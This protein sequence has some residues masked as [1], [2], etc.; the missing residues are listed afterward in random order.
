M[1]SIIRRVSAILMAAIF[2]FS[3]PISAYAIEAN[4]SY[5][6]VNIGDTQVTHTKEEGGSAVTEDHGGSV[7]VTGSTTENNISVNVSEGNSV[8]VTLQ[9]VT[10]DASNN[11]EAA[12][13]ISGAGDVVVELDGN[14]SLEGGKYHAGLETSQDGGSLIIQDEVDTNGDEVGNGGSLTAEGG[15]NGA[16]IGGGKAGDGSNISISGGDVTANGGNAGAGIGGGHGGDG[17]EISISGGV[18]TATGGTQAAGIGGGDTNYDGEGGDGSNIE[19]TGGTVTANG[20]KYGAGIGGGN[21]GS[22]IDITISGDAVVTAT[23]GTKG[24]GIGGGEQG[25]GRNIEISGGE[26][27]ATGG[28]EAAGVGGGGTNNSTTPGGTG[29]DISISGGEVTATGGENAAGIGGGCGASGSDISISGD[30]QVTATGSGNAADVGSGDLQDGVKQEN[31]VD[32]SGLYT[33]G[34]F[35]GVAGIVEP[36]VESVE[37]AEESDDYSYYVFAPAEPFTVSENY[38]KTEKDGVLTVTVRGEEAEL[39]ITV[40]GIKK[41]IADGIHT[42]VFVTDQAETKVDL[43]ELVKDCADTDEFVISHKGDVTTI[44]CNGE[45]VK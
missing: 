19:I 15:K 28:K 13:D 1:T 35:G 32:T 14:N 8:E 23:G 3:I 10:V 44:T 11:N 36:P 22:G 27:T 21:G 33:T 29:S 17:S 16:G 6:D 20:S 42:L 4:V 37:A 38:T 26:V 41:L 24:A 31:D 30:A 12:M 45:E 39:E 40:S 5:G 18:V 9:D 2:T 43:K 34:S 7:T 25:D